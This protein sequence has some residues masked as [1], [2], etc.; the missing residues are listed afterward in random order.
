M[1][2]VMWDQ[3]KNE[4]AAELGVPNYDEL[5]KG[6]LPSRVNGMVGGM[7]VRKMINIAEQVME[8][9]GV[10]PSIYN[11]QSVTTEDQQRVAETLAVAQG[12]PAYQVPQES[13]TEQQL[14]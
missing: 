7:M 12:I 6:L 10:H 1:K 14:H 4:T 11:D 3:F 13:Y 8:N 5:D 9:G 2:G